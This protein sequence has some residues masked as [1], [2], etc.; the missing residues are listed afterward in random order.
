MSGQWFEQ[1]K[2]MVPSLP[3]QYR[4]KH[5]DTLV[6]ICGDWISETRLTALG[7]IL[8]YVHYANNRKDILRLLLE[9]GAD[10]NVV[11]EVFEVLTEDASWYATERAETADEAHV[12]LEA[13]ATIRKDIYI[14]LYPPECRAP[15]RSVFLKF[16]EDSLRATALVWCIE[17]LRGTS[18]WPDM[19]FLLT[20]IIM[21]VSK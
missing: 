20:K 7:W 8:S 1:A 13:G 19:S 14:L 21:D 18:S 3:E 9:L 15:A 16:Y 6:P 10:P 11:C 4:D 5:I 17:A 12:L 2:V